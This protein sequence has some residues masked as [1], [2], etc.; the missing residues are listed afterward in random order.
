MTAVSGFDLFG[1]VL[2]NEIV[3]VQ[4]PSIL[5]AGTASAGF[6]DN[7]LILYDTYYANGYIVLDKNTYMLKKSVPM[8]ERLG[9]YSGANRV[10][11][12]RGRTGGSSGF[13]VILYTE[14]MVQMKTWTETGFFGDF[15][16][17]NTNIYVSQISGENLIIKMYDLNGNLVRTSQSLLGGVYSGGGMFLREGLLSIMNKQNSLYILYANTLAIRQTISDLPSSFSKT[18]MLGDTV[19]VSNPSNNTNRLYSIS[20]G[21]LLRTSRYAVLGA[22][23]D[24]YYAHAYDRAFFG[25]SNVS[26]FVAL[27]TNLGILRGTTDTLN[28][29]SRVVFDMTSKQDCPTILGINGLNNNFFSL[30]KDTG[31]QVL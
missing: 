21:A 29:G 1:G 25:S 23:K 17:S 6:T 4:S 8:S 13:D 12:T 15:L 28:T 22:S 18:A 5:G 9:V 7:N 11:L 26:E 20:T 16:I 14:D 24:A 31:G 19:A 27:N 10:V 30:L 2:T 3:Q